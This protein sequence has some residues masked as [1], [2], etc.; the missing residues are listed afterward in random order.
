MTTYETISIIISAIGV[1][2]AII[3]AYV[4]FAQLK[5]MTSSVEAA[6]AANSI[7]TLNAVLTLE[8]SITDNRI[9]FSDAAVT[10]TKLRPEDSEKHKNATI[11]A[12]KEARENYLN[13]M[14]RFC[15][16]IL[17]GQFPEI[18][19][20]KD[21][22]NAVNDIITHENYK[23]L[24]GTGTRYRNIVKIYDKWADE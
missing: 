16:C 4:Y 7:A 24:M 15:A 1:A 3:A 11:L 12:F 20:R 22:R 14:D 10:V 23:E 19:Y 2:A 5:K 18:D 8:K 17:R 13:S 6:I 9:R 21:Y